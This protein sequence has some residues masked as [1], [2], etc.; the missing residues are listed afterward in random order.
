MP[1]AAVTSRTGRIPLDQLH[2]A[3]NAVLRSNAFSDRGGAITNRFGGDHV[4]DRVGEPPHR[5]T[6]D[7]Y[8]SGGDPEF[9]EA[10][11][12]ERLVGEER[13]RDRGD[14]GPET[15]AGRAGS[16]VV[17]DGGHPWEHPVVR[18]GVDAEHMA[19]KVGLG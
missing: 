13:N 8:R 16:T 6:P 5:D 4:A 17:H 15:G 7:R 10:P 3:G 14:A 2:G 11:G 9:M 1:P 18:Y 19:R 12:P